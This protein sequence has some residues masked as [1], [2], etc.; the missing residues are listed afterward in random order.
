VSGKRES[1]P[2]LAQA[3][4]LTAFQAWNH[5]RVHVRVKKR[6]LGRL[7]AKATHFKVAASESALRQGGLGFLRPSPCVE[8]LT[9]EAIIE[10]HTETWN[11]PG[12]DQPVKRVVMDAQ[13]LGHI[14]DRHHRRAGVWNRFACSCH[15]PK[16]TWIGKRQK[17]VAPPSC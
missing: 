13:K 10:A 2:F 7:N 9:I 14:L 4:P 16:F 11:L 3:C 17:P 15:A 6:V 12:L 1:H 8:G 5:T